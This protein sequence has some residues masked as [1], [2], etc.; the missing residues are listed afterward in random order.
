MGYGYEIWDMA[1]VLGIFPTTC[2]KNIAD[3]EMAWP[4]HHLAV[5]LA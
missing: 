4:H 5:K 1:I 2:E 3:I